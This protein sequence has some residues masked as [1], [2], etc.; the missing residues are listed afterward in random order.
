MRPS[1][2]SSQGFIASTSGR[3]WVLRTLRRSSAVRPR[4]R[5]SIP[6]AIHSRRQLL[7]NAV[8]AASRVSA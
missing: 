2:A 1:C 8:I 6:S 3:D 5:F 4:M 7:A